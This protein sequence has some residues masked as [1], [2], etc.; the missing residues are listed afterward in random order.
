MDMANIFLMPI[1]HYFGDYLGCPILDERPKKVDFKYVMDKIHLKLAGWKSKV[2]A[3][4][5]RTP[6]IKYYVSCII[7]AY[8]MQNNTSMFLQAVHKAIDKANRARRGKK[9]HALGW[10]KV[11]KP[12]EL[13]GLGIRQFRT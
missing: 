11:T 10:E 4:V 13:R 8:V 7:P 1:A 12:T 2:L 5:G 3:M 6:L 9:F